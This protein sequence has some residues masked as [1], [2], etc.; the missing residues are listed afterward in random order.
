[1]APPA[2]LSSLTALFAGGGAARFALLIFAAAMVLLLPLI[3]PELSPARLLPP[4]VADSL[5]VMLL[6]LLGAALLVWRYPGGATGLAA[7]LLLLAVVHVARMGVDGVHAPLANEPMLVRLGLA[8]AVVL[9]AAGA[10]QRWTGPS[11]GFM[12]LAVA[13]L[14][15][16]VSMF[17]AASDPYESGNAASTAFP[18][19]AD[20]AAP[21]AAMAAEVTQTPMR[22]SLQTLPETL[23]ARAPMTATLEEHMVQLRAPPGRATVNWNAPA[24]GGAFGMGTRAALGSFKSDVSDLQ[25]RVADSGGA[26]V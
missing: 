26:D 16:V 1:M 11:T 18:T 13:A 2:F 8:A 19:A 7:A 3:L 10:L 25:Q 4:A 24:Y 21:V 9:G 22:V 14:I 20:A 17:A 15:H 6:T 12:V 5:P 23:P